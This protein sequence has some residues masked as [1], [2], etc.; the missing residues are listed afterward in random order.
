MRSFY[1]EWFRREGWGV[2]DVAGFHAPNIIP[3]GTHW[4]LLYGKDYPYLS[5]EPRKLHL[6]DWLQFHWFRV[7]NWPRW[8]YVSVWI[9]DGPDG[10]LEVSC[11][12]TDPY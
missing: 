4:Y 5:F 10:T 6:A 3:H 12:V 11:V 8:F 7:D 9:V 1:E 2:H